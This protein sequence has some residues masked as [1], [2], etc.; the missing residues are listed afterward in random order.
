MVSLHRPV[1]ITEFT[2][3]QLLLR[4]L[5][6]ALRHLYADEDSEEHVIDVSSSMSLLDDCP[7]LRS[8][9]MPQLFLNVPHQM[10]GTFSKEV[11]AHG[12]QG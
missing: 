1:K 8:P 11:N 9:Q 7:R 3:P 5:G 4:Q 10:L 2:K 12:A 6:E